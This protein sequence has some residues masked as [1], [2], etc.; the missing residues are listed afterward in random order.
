M[1]SAI[2]LAATVQTIGIGA[3]IPATMHL[4]VG[5]ASSGSSISFVNHV[6]GLHRL[7]V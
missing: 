2:A 7:A 6:L 4:P 5:A 3:R 1:L